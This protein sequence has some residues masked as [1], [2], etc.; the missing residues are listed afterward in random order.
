[1]IIDLLKLL[2]KTDSK[3]KWLLNIMLSKLKILL[4]KFGIVGHLL[5][6][7]LKKIG[8]IDLDLDLSKLLSMNMNIII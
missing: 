5:D 4:F 3:M 8:G 7:I 1:M 6:M 2:L